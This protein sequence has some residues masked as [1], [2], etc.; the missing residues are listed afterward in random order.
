MEKEC[1]EC[2]EILDESYFRS[3][4]HNGKLTIKGKCKKCENERMKNYYIRKRNKIIQQRKEFRKKNPNNQK[5]Q[6]KKL[7]KKR[8]VVKIYRAIGR[9]IRKAIDDI[10][11]WKSILDFNEEQLKEW[12]E[13][14]F[15]IDWDL[16]MTHQN[17]GIVWEIDHVKPISSFD[18]TKKNQ[19]KVAFSWKNTIPRLCS[20]NKKKSNKILHI[21]I[22]EINKRVRVFE[23]MKLLKC[24]LQP[25][26][27]INK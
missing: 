19:Q 4:V 24:Q 22:K 5:E 8:P 15:M 2:G 6:I 1:S 11:N 23:M 21:E 17:H 10:E 13:Y 16:E 25:V 14:N 20:D 26:N 7:F 12:L 27:T 3:Y 9:R 18:L